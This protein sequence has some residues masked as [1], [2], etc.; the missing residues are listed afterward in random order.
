LAGFSAFESFANHC[1]STLAE[2]GVLAVY[3][4]VWDSPIIAR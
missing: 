3:D 4:L 1:V 2:C